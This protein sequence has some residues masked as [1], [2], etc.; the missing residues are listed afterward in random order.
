MTNNNVFDPLN[1]L[2]NIG[3]KLNNYEQIPSPGS[4]YTILGKGHFAYAEK[5]RSKMNNQIICY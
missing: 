4:N 3:T 2:R 5:M 1:K